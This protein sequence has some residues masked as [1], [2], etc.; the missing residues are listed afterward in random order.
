MKLNLKNIKISTK[1]IM[2]LSEII[3]KMG[4]SEELKNINGDTTE[5][6]GTELIILLITNLHKADY[7]IYKF[8]ANYK[9][10]FDESMTEDNPEYVKMYDQAIKKAQKEDFVAVMKEILNIE[11]VTDFL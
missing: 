5:E 2:L 7:E 8:I 4:I 11:G 6:V 1:D 9:N 3:S 10:Y